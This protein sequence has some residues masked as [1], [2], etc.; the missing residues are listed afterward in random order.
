MELWRKGVLVC[1]Y[2]PVKDSINEDEM[3]DKVTGKGLK[4]VMSDKFT[5]GEE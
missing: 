4:S 2:I 3:F 5:Y 1:D